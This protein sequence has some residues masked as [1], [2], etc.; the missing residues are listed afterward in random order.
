MLFH[1]FF[2]YF[3]IFRT[4]LVGK[5]SN[6]NWLICVKDTN[7]V[8]FL[9]KGFSIIRNIQPY[10]TVWGSVIFSASIQDK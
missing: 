8:R 3:L 10:E 5:Y 2:M 4:R 1:G 6:I 7:E 9:I